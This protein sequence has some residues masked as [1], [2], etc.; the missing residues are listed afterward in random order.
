MDSKW[1]L[2]V[3]DPVK[4]NSDGSNYTE[5]ASAW[6]NVLDYKEMWDTFNDTPPQET[7]T[8]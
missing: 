1:K 2:D 7:T 5:R 4:L 6:E 8:E 3:G